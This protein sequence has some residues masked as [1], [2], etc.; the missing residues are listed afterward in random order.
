MPENR[1][2]T[3]DNAI[4][5]TLESHLEAASPGKD[6]WPQIR[7]RVGV[8][9]STCHRKRWT[10]AAAS[11]GIALAIVGVVAARWATKTPAEAV[12]VTQAF[13]SL[14]KVSSVYVYQET[15]SNNMGWTALVDGIPEGSTAALS[16]IEPG[17]CQMIDQV[18]SCALIDR[19]TGQRVG[20][21]EST[22]GTRMT[23]GWYV[24]PDRFYVC[25]T[26]QMDA[27]VFNQSK[28]TAVD[29]LLYVDG[30]AYSR[31]TRSGK[32]KYWTQS[33]QDSSSVVAPSPERLFWG[34]FQNRPESV[35][36]VL[37]REFRDVQ[38]LEPALIDGAPVRH[39]RVQP[40]PQGGWSQVLDIWIGRDDG[41]PRKV[42]SQSQGTAAPD[43]FQPISQDIYT[44]SRF[45][46]T[47]PVPG[48]PKPEE[49]RSFPP[50]SAT[51]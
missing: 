23:E 8:P 36:D 12:Y 20:T 1:R 37:R 4:K 44:F 17:N 19:S 28:T 27:E 15:R 16:G 18:R 43:G 34:L 26:E 41:L 48:A 3:D 5:T 38:E 2:V 35:V 24:F 31:S 39:F 49:V 51:P 25:T 10:V 21:S 47:L 7:F 46:E 45:N 29:E 50:V 11:F 30:R 40:P 22:S 32:A 14:Y 6:L 9:P 33:P 13:D 42:V